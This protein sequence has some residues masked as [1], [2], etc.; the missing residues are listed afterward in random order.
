MSVAKPRQRVMHII[1]GLDM[2]GAE[3]QLVMLA[4]ERRRR[5][6]EDV[7]VS[8]LKGGALRAQLEAAGVPVHDLGMRRGLPSP[9]AF[10]RLVR[11]IRRYRPAVVQSWMYHADLLATLALRCSGRWYETP[12]VW[13]VRCSDMDVRS[14]SFL[15]RFVLRFCARL[16]AMPNV[17]VANSESGQRVHLGLGYKPFRWRVIDNGVDTERYHP[18]DD[19]RSAVRRELGIPPAAPVVAHVARVD[20]MKDHETALAALRTLPD[21]HAI[22]TGAGTEALPAGANWHRLGRRSDIAAL[23]PAADMILSSSAYGEGFSN[24]LAEGMASGLPAVGTNVGDSRRVV[25]KAGHIVPARDS[26]AMAAAI[27]AVAALPLTDR[28]ALK[29]AARARMVDLFSVGLC[30]DQYEQLYV[31]LG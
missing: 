17:I 26:A 13:G 31:S 2:G 21:V 28:A 15:F 5:G 7:V 22:F 20:P 8:L 3:T 27:H 30:A 14:Y 29:I 23:L 16:S 25:G 10:L 11:L 1:T 9:A 12:L 19:Q 6:G 18:D 24:A 4:C